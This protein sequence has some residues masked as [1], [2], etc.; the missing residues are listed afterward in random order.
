MK[1]EFINPY[2]FDLDLDLKETEKQGKEI[3]EFTNNTLSPFH[4]LINGIAHYP[5]RHYKSD[6]SS[7]PRITRW[8]RGFEPYRW[9]RSALGH[10]QMYQNGYLYLRDGT[11]VYFSR[12]KADEFYK[13]CIIVEGELTEKQVLANIASPI[14]WVV[15]RIVG[16]WNFKK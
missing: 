13:C 15:L 3:F 11:K 1:I 5:D 4:W 10:D 9:K 2:N 8:I 6:L 14:Q 16:W 12:E 7:T